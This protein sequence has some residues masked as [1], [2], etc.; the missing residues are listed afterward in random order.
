MASILGTA[1]VYVL[2][3]ASGTDVVRA[4]RARPRGW[5]SA[6]FHLLTVAAVGVA[7]SSLPGLHHPHGIDLALIIVVLGLMLPFALRLAFSS[8]SRTT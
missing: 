8:A 2:S 7:W 4:L 6:M 5:I 1:L 3:I